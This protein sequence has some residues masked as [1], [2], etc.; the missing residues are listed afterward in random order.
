MTAPRVAPGVVVPGV[1]VREQVCQVRDEAPGFLILEVHEEPCEGLGVAVPHLGHRWFGRF[2]QRDDDTAP[3]IFVMLAIHQ[4]R[5]G[6]V[7]DD[8]AGVGDAHV[9]ALGQ[10]RYGG[11]PRHS[12]RDE[13]GNVTLAV[14]PAHLQ[15][16]RHLARSPSQGERQLRKKGRQAGDVLVVIFLQETLIVKD[17]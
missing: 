15:D 3:I 14:A 17:P 10:L 9:D 5:P 16:S 12:E 4:P 2:R 1:E 8:H 11:G 13:G 6:E 7:A